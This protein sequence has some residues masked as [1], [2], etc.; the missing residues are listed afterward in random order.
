MAPCA[1]S[2]SVTADELTLTLNTQDR[3]EGDRRLKGPRRGRRPT[4]S[5]VCHQVSRSTAMVVSAGGS[6]AF[7]GRIALF[8]DDI[9][10]MEPVQRCVHDLACAT[11]RPGP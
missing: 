8:A 2:P 4:Q 10:L 1:L 7:L 5:Q 3:V 6:A 11:E 9:R